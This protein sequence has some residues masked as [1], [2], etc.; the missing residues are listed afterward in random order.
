MRPSL[1]ELPT[2]AGDC[3]SPVG[4]HDRDDRD[5]SGAQVPT[6]SDPGVYLQKPTPRRTG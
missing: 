6:R 1:R 5:K 4:S 2:V 3:K